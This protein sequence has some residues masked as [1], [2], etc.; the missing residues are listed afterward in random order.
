MG[1]WLFGGENAG[2]DSIDVQCVLG[3]RSK[4]DLFGMEFCDY[5]VG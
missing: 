2:G 4:R 1:V 5:L 3:D